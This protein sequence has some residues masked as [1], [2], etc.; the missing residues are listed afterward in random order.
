[1]TTP[2]H[3][4]TEEIDNKKTVVGIFIDLSKAFDTIDHDIL[5]DKLCL[6]GI[7]GTAKKWFMSYLRNQQQYVQIQHIKSDLRTV[8]SG[9]PHYGIVCL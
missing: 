3:V 5:L 9:V 4:F 1:M 6:F 2:I 7:R 8:K